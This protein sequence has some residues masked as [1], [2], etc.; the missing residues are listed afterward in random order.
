MP[1]RTFNAAE[2]RKIFSLALED[3]TQFLTAADLFGP[4]AFF[5][6]TYITE[7]QMAG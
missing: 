3:K 1:S 7:Q 6:Q 5:L 2:T 4:A